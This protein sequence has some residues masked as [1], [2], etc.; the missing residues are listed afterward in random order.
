MGRFRGLHGGRANLGGDPRADR[1][2]RPELGWPA[3]L[4]LEGSDQFRGW[5]NSSLTT[6]VAVFGLPPYR[7]VLGHGFVLDG[8]GRKMSKSL[9]NIVDPMDVMKTYGADILR[10][11]VASVD[12][13][14]DVRISEA[15][16]GQIAEVYRKVRNTFRF[17]LGNTSDFDPARDRVP[18]ERRKSGR[19]TPKTPIAGAWKLLG[20]AISSRQ[21][22][23]ACPDSEHPQEHLSPS[24]NEGLAESQP[25]TGRTNQSFGALSAA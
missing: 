1:R 14:A 24:A 7:T 22:G 10:L 16:L 23:T 17:L 3:D 12:Y 21:T 4:Y 2:S 9:G 13:T 8:E 11:W 5:F 20:V 6:A 18:P 15:I 19:P 25:G